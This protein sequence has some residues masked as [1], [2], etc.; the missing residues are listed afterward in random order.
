MKELVTPVLA[1]G[2]ALVFSGTPTSPTMP[3]E[4]LRVDCKCCENTEVPQGHR[5]TTTSCGEESFQLQAVSS[6]RVA[7][8]FDFAPADDET[9]EGAP[10]AS[11]LADFAA[12]TS[13][14]LLFVKGEPT[15]CSGDDACLKNLMGGM[16]GP[17]HPTPFHTDI[18]VGPS[19]QSQHG[20]CAE[21]EEAFAIFELI[22]S[23]DYF[24]LANLYESNHELIQFNTERRM[25]QVT[26]CGNRIVAQ[27]FVDVHRLNEALA[28]LRAQKASASPR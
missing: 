6:L 8:R 5:F 20:D 13:A 25:L 9:N 16:S 11:S 14:E 19:C 4:M 7:P 24:R 26:A 27:A 22:E 17:H 28:Q 1:V 18:T 15:A 10:S 23:K 12:A 3:A 2:V 21:P